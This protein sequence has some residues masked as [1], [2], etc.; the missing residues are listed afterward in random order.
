LDKYYIIK[1][2]KTKLEKNNVY[3]KLE[4]KLNYVLNVKFIASSFELHSLFFDRNFTL[5]SLIYRV[6]Q[7]NLMSLKGHIPEGILKR[8]FL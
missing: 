7:N 8:L 6:I 3:F 4:K 5:T 1:T 2:I